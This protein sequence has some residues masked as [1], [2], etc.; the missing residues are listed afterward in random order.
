[1]ALAATLPIAGFLILM[2]L[3]SQ[4]TL[5]GNCNKGTRP[6]YD[7]SASAEDARALGV[8]RDLLPTRKSTREPQ[9]FAW[10]ITRRLEHPGERRDPMMVGA[11]HVEP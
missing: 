9:D 6:S 1:M 3:V 8:L 2:L 7:K 5:Y 4:F 10:F 11:Q